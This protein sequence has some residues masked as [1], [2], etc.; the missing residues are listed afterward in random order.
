MVLAGHVPQSRKDQTIMDTILTC[1]ECTKGCYVATGGSASCDYCRKPLAMADVQLEV[2]ETLTTTHR[3]G[4][5]FWSVQS[6]G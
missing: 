1:S 2:G 6:E 5:T 4:Q 3:D